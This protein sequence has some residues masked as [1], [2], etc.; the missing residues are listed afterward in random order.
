[1]AGKTLQEW[2]DEA[3]HWALKAR[4]IAAK[5]EKEDRDFTAEETAELR[6]HMAKAVAAKAEIEKLK[7]N[8]ELRRTLAELGDDIALDAKTDDD[9]TRRTASGFQ[10]PSRKKTLGQEFIET[11]EY[12]ALM[13]QATD[14]RFGA[15][16][17]VQSGLAGFKSL[18]TG[19]SDTSAGAFV[20]PDQ[21]G[22]QVGLDSFKR[23]LRLRD[24]VTPGTTTSDSVE[25]V[26]MTSY[27]NNAAPVPEA[28]SSANPTAPGGAGALV[29]NAGGGYKPESGLAAVKINTAVKTI[30]HWMPITKRAIS[31]AAQVVTLI[32][33]FLRYGLEEELEDQMVQGDGT[34][35]NFEGVANVSGV[36]SQAWDTNAFTT[37][38]K[39]KT[40]VRTVGR[41]IPNGVLVNPVDLET[42]DLLQD[43]ENRYYF[44][45][46]AG[47][48]SAQTVWN[49]PIIETEAVP[50]GTAYVGD[51]RK[52]ILWDRQQATIQ[53]TDSHMDFFV[54]NLVVILAEMR[55]AFGVIQ[56]SAFVEVDLAA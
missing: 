50:A 36:Q 53:M 45:G 49:M 27:T 39:A 26:R 55:A 54:R 14:G 12:K 9:G 21:L 25:Y 20:V 41:S 15:K 8:D 31:D 38:R 52:A 46:P 10:L 6:E 47:V 7:G 37:L 1:M 22:L 19:G 51:W 13:G 3:K 28:T 23:P 32:D 56:P 43:N 35:E 30:A 40:K 24:L 18:V 11:P 34:G 17:R 42:L 29:P 16:Q 5:C 2:I 44:G 33:A 48:G 4:D